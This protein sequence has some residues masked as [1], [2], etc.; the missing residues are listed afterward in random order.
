[1]CTVELVIGIILACLV[2][3]AFGH[4]ACGQFLLVIIWESCCCIRG[5]TVNKC[6]KCLFFSILLLF[7]SASPITVIKENHKICKIITIF[8][9]K[10]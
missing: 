2:I 3:E 5:E 7:F 10:H 9:M 4:S 8:F 1:M 6:R